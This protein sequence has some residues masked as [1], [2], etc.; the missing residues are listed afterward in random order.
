M[1]AGGRVRRG[2]PADLGPV[3]ALAQEVLPEAGSRDSLARSLASPAAELFVAAAE[4]AGVVD[5]FLMALRVGVELEVLWLG[6]A[7]RARR[8]GLATDLLQAALD[9]VETC[10]LEVSEQRPEAQAF[11][12]AQGFRAVARRRAYHPGGED[13]VRM[14][15]VAE[16]APRE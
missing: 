14:Q 2:G 11:Y 9:G 5:G 13:A 12:H 3:A 15:W 8:G 7:P 4:P 1:K 16:A 10:H 6:V